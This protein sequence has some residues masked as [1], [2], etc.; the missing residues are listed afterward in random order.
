MMVFSERLA[1]CGM[2]Y[3]FDAGGRAALALDLC[4]AVRENIY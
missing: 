4:Q 3:I 1:Y 2:R